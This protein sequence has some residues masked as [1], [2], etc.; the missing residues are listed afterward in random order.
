MPELRQDGYLS[1]SSQLLILKI[2]SL[3]QIKSLLFLCLFFKTRI[4]LD[5]R[6]LAYFLDQRTYKDSNQFIADILKTE[7]RVTLRYDQLNRA[8]Q[9]S[10]SSTIYL[11]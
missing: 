6:L 11:L 10:F 5:D 4:Y 7:A 9:N 2:C 3:S 1:S 8:N